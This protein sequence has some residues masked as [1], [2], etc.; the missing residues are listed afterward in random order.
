MKKISL[1]LFIL[2]L[3]ACN[4]EPAVTTLKDPS[5]DQE[6]LQKESGLS[7][8]LAEELYDE[9]PV[10]IKT[11]L[12]NEGQYDFGHGEYY[13]IEVKKSGEWY[14]VIH[15]DAVFLNNP[16]LKDFG[17]RLSAGGMAEQDFSIDLLGITLLPGEYRL[18]KT[19]L[20]LDE[21]FFEI[22][23]AAPFTVE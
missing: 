22:S 2:I 6:L 15:S 19:F 1:I 14:T 11:A 7:L 21:P 16:Q 10:S 8:S 5:P 9:S 12:K 18:V 20:S 23:L 13:Y 17:S 3:T 4:K